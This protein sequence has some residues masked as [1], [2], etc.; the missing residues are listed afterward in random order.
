[1]KCIV[2]PFARGHYDSERDPDGGIRRDMPGGDGASR[3]G[4]VE[5]SP[6]RS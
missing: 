4:P 1:M 2:E 3:V 6:Q 5:R